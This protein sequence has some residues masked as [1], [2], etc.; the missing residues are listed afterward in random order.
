MQNLRRCCVYQLLAANTDAAAYQM[1][2]YKNSD[3]VVILH[4]F[5]S[6]Q[7]NNYVAFWLLYE[8]HKINAV[9]FHSFT[10]AAIPHVKCDV[11]FGRENVEN[12]V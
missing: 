9:C 10:I 8:N 4:Y 1:K 3:L 11:G 7:H 12:N 5:N 6:F 2:E